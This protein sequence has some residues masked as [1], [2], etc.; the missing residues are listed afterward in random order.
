MF[1]PTE[2]EILS[3][4]GVS[5]ETLNDL[6][7]FSASVEKWSKSIN[8]VA[9]STVAEF[10]QRH[11]LDGVQLLSLAPNSPGHWCDLGSGGGLPGIVIALILR[12]TSPI[13]TVTLI[14]SDARKAAFLKL[15]ARN[16]QLATKIV[17]ARIEKAPEENADVVSARALAPLDILLGLVSRHLDSDGVAILPK[18]KRFEQEVEQARRSWHFEMKVERSAVDEESRVLL[19]SEIAPKVGPQ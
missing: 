9:S 12:E 15:S 16:Y 18:G 6:R 4:N 7:S 3:K 10:W 17:C 2:Q 11:I 1:L 5:R 14:E 19:V 13:T 8:L